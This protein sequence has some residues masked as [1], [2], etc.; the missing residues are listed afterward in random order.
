MKILS[1]FICLTMILFS[2]ILPTFSQDSNTRE[3]NPDRP[4]FFT[5]KSHDPNFL[6]SG[7]LSTRSFYQRKSDWQHIIDSTWG[8][9]APLAEKL[10]IYN[11]Y[12]QTIHYK[13][14]VLCFLN[15]NWDSL[16]NHYLSQITESTS[17]GAFSA[18]MSHFAYALKDGHTLALDRT[19][20]FS[21]LNPGIPVLLIGSYMSVEHFGAVTTVLPD[22]TTLV[23]RVAPNHPLNLEPGDI[24]LGYEGVSW[25]NLVRELFDAGLPM[26]ASTGGCKSADTYQN[27]CGAGLNWHL[28][29]TIDILRNSIGDTVH[30]SVTPMLNLNVPT[31]LNNE[32]LAIQNIPFPKFNPME[33]VDSDT[34]VTYGILEKT[35]IGYI[36]LSSHLPTTNA[37]EQFYSAINAMK[38]T[39]ALIIDMRLNPGGRAFFEKAFNILFNEYHKTLESA[40]RC[41]S[42]TFELCP[43]GFWADYQI[44]GKDPDYYDRPIAVLLGPTC[45]SRGDVT[46]QQLRY[47]PMVKFFGASSGASLGFARSIE[48]IPDWWLGYSDADMFHTSQP[49][50]YLNRKEFPIDYPVWFNKDDVAKG[51]D[52]IVEKSLDWIN[53][54]AYGHD[55]S[56]EKG[57]YLPGNDTVKIN[58]IVEN[59]N[60]HQISAK[61][62]FESMDGSVIDS[63]EMEKINLAGGN[64]WQGKWIT[65]GIVDNIY[66]ISL[67]VTDQTDGTSFNNKHATRFTTVP[68]LVDNLP[69]TKTS[70]SK[71]TF[72]PFIK[73]AGKTGAI[74]KI[75]LNPSSKDPWVKGINPEQ[76]TITYL[77]VGQTK[78]TQAF[79]VSY[80][81]ANFPGYFN[82]KFKIAT[83]GW[84]YWEID[85]TITITPN[86]IKPEQ[87]LPLANCLD[88]NYPNPFNSSTTIRW[89]LAHSSQATLKVFD[90]VG[91]EVSIPVDEQR[92][93]GKYETEFNAATLPKGVYFY[94]LKAGEFVQTRKMI[95]MK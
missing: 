90:L 73:N 24:I 56:A 38:N 72:T 95:L 89:Q 70:E 9:G 31:M 94:R 15:T 43:A 17:K 81:A 36:F 93:A 13:S 7:K 29:S 84:S 47:H 40:M 27:L 67:K 45:V 83:D 71:Y 54:L 4:L 91:R 78:A 28:F 69:Y 35:N 44:N 82:L 10:R 26:G 65:P 85:T 76:T 87:S 33:P 53:N 30:L 62:I 1:F 86:Y 80:D 64:Q 92:P 3:F 23:L 66:W 18:I 37:D 61:L 11:T 58:A 60:S 6:K 74:T 50:V 46:A 25:K 8:P 32:Q 79:V 12:A 59:P 68:L 2:S 20:V 5:P 57:R 88:Q 77:S 52:P 19:V 21:A 39:D 42:N 48:N 14:D 34:I 41:N 63:T 49:D 16:Y 51:I 75:T 55:I 22:S